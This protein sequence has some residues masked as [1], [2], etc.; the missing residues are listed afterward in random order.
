MDYSVKEDFIEYIIDK[1][2]YLILPS[3]ANKYKSKFIQSRFLLCLVMF[4][5]V[6]KLTTV[7]LSVNF[8]QN[9]FFA[10]ITKIALENFANQ[11]RQAVGLKPLVNNSKLDQAAKLKAENMVQNNY[12]NHNSPSG[13]TPWFWF[14]KAGYNYKYAGENLAIGF[15]DSKELFNAW[16]NSPSHRENILNPNY[17]EMGTAVLPGYGGGNTV[18]V[19]QE[20]GSQLP[21]AVAQKPA[22]K[23]VVTV[24]PAVQNLKTSPAQKPE[25]TVNTNNERVLSQTTETIEVNN[26]NAKNNFVS[27]ALNTVLYNYESILQKTIY[28][29]SFIVIGALM[30]IIFFNSN[31]Q[32]KRE[33]IFRSLLIIALLCISTLL[34]TSIL[35][36][37]VSYNITI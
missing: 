35:H 36:S 32:F 23:P 29:V 13:I 10:D 26:E 1:T 22:A 27:K 4:L 6:L 5:L 21:G 24:T 16:L 25:S 19:V 31:V 17:K 28:G 14:A 33:L 9:I 12:F 8:S 11:A 34:N 3:E 37:F 20:F 2:K 15:F 18:V 30:V 7:L